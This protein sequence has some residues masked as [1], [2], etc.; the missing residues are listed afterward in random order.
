MR[1]VPDRVA[2]PGRHHRHTVTLQ[3]VHVATDLT[4]QQADAVEIAHHV[5][6][7]WDIE[8][9]SHH[10]RSTAWTVAAFRRY[11]DPAPGATV[12]LRQLTIGA[13]HL[14]GQ[15]GIAVSLRHH[16]PLTAFGTT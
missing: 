5:R 4:T 8:N 12:S 6:D 13:L 9:R 7:Y 15:A 11:M 14:A 2:P 10:V 1:R 16:T 3:R